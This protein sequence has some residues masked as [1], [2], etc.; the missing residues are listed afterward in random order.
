MLSDES[1]KPLY[2]GDVYNDAHI[3]VD[4][5][6]NHGKWVLDIVS[7]AEDPCYDAFARIPIRYC[8]ICGR[9]L[10]DDENDDKGGWIE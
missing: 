10:G 9:K 4:M 5:Y 6:G 2:R 3:D 8:P 7:R 1:Y